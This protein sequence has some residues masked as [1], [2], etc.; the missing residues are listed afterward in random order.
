MIKNDKINKKIY[1]FFHFL[2][3]SM[4]YINILLIFS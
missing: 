4:E 1:I 3:I 2:G